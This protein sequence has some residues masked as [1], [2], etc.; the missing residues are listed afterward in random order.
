MAAFCPKGGWKNQ[1]NVP[2][3]KAYG[4]DVKLPL[5]LL[6]C[7]ATSFTTVLG[8]AFLLNL[9]TDSREQN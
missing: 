9:H 8:P 3:K 4:D 1:S 6:C 2:G 5:L 7:I